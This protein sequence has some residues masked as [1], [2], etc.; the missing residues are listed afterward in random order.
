MLENCNAYSASEVLS[1]GSLS[2]SECLHLFARALTNQ[3]SI[4]TATVQLSFLQSPFG[5]QDI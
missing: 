2:Y 1:C 4:F 5:S 3:L